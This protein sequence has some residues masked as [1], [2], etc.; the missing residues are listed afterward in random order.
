VGRLTLD[1]DALANYVTA[2]LGGWPA[3]AA[4]PTHTVVWAVDHGPADITRVMR[5]TIAARVQRDLAA[6]DEIG[7][8]ARYFDGAEGQATAG[9]L[10]QALADHSPAFVLTT[11]HGKTGP[12]GDHDALVRD[13]G[14][15][16]DG[17]YATVDPA[18]VLEAWQPD[19][20][21]WYAHACCSAGSDGSTIYR[22]LLEPGSWVDQVLTGIA[23]AGTHVAPLPEALLGATRPLRA[24]IG[25]VEPTFDWTIK[26]PHNGQR[27]TA[28]IC[29]ALYD[30]FFTPQ[31][32]GLALREVYALVGE[33][34]GQRDTAYRDFD[35]GADTAAVAMA[36]TLAARDRQSMVILGDPTVAVPPL[37]S[38]TRSS[39]R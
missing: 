38:R 13:L 8:N 19:G 14:L 5:T 27:L 39:A 29:T 17:D 23:G 28:T 6:D 1:G 10:Y 34:F 22:G 35:A 9:A 24:F 20:A 25:H 32:V 26:N 31:P 11:S 3:S 36:T 2:L 37:P 18:R 7:P 4:Q 33:L 15:P 21:V 16:V 30:K 12:L